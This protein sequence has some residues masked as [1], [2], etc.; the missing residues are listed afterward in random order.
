MLEYNNC[1]QAA[2]FYQ[3]KEK[4]KKQIQKYIFIGVIL[5]CCYLLVSVGVVL[6]IVFG[7]LN[8]SALT[9][10]EA[11]STIYVSPNTSTSFITTKTSTQLNT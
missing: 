6:G 1:N 9:S 4:R 2:V 8:K 10:N 7:V 5:L 11:Y 3:T